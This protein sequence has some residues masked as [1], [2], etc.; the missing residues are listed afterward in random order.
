MKQESA[1]LISVFHSDAP[2]SGW[3]GIEDLAHVPRIGSNMG[4]YF[5]SFWQVNM[6][7]WRFEYVKL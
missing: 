4:I 3:N 5:D 1:A 2:C 6:L 7:L